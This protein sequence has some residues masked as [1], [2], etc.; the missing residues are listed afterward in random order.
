MEITYMSVSYPAPVEL[1]MNFLQRPIDFNK[2][3]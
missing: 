1:E 2:L 3:T